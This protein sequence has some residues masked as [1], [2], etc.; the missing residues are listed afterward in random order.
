MYP[1]AR[2][3]CPGRE[4]MA[5]ENVNKSFRSRILENIFLEGIERSQCNYDKL[6]HASQASI[7][8][9]NECERNLVVNRFDFNIIQKVLWTVYIC[10]KLT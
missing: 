8:T 7:T 1:S 4:E 5:A 2:P 9:Q 10:D 3:H 6:G